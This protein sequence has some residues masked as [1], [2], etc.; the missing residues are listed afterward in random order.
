M[1]ATVTVTSTRTQS[2]TGTATATATESVTQT[3]T[4]TA[5]E[6]VTITDTE[7]E[8]VTQ[9]LTEEI[10]YTATQTSTETEDVTSTVTPTATLTLTAVA[11]GIYMNN[12]AVLSQ[13]WWDAGPPFI[14]SGNCML[15]SDEACTVPIPAAT[16][17]MNGVVLEPVFFM[18]PGRYS[19][20]QPG[21]YY[22]EGTTVNFSVDT[23]TQTASASLVSLGYPR[24]WL[25]PQVPFPITADFSIFWNY[26]G[27]VPPLVH[28]VAYDI[29]GPTPYTYYV[30][31]YI[32]GTNTSFTFK[33]GMLQSPSSGYV[34]IVVEVAQKA[35]IT[36]D[37]AY[38][39][40]FIF[41]NY[42][43]TLMNIVP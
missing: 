29:F 3:H 12:V 23:G 36:G 43:Y 19:Y 15:F 17:T 1:T 11:G 37:V 20:N 38:P 16:V 27:D 34:M 24:L 10:S 33:A 6:T 22:D 18:E 32:P 39:Y 8:T 40:E 4:Q 35:V 31:T 9:T 26:V 5:T 42:D 21:L 14:A 2:A 25:M 30:D 41:S 28:V 13:P 7:T